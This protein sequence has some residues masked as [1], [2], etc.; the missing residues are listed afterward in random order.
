M[1]LAKNAWISFLHNSWGIWR[2]NKKNA[3][4]AE[5]PLYPLLNAMTIN[6]CLILSIACDLKKIKA[7]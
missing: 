4:L 2:G 7:V 3:F 1:C 6:S 5:H